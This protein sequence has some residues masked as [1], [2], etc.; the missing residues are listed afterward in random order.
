[1]QHRPVSPRVVSST[2]A[3]ASM[4]LCILHPEHSLAVLILQK[5]VP[6]AL[7]TITLLLTWLNS[8][9]TSDGAYADM[10]EHTKASSGNT[11]C[12]KLSAGML[13][14]M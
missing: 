2:A 6:M 5:Q 10:L 7:N 1:M 14:V 13:L 3:P 9:T 8:P 12:F 11:S 4:S